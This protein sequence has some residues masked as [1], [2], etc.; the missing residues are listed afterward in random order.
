MAASLR[1]PPGA[2]DAT[3]HCEIHGHDGIEEDTRDKGADDST[4]LGEAGLEAVGGLGSEGDGDGEREDDSR[5]AQREG[6]TQAQRAL[7][8]LEQVA[9]GVVDGRDGGFAPPAVRRAPQWYSSL[10]FLRG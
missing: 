7:A 4:G 2:D 10:G 3:Q 9:S 6:E 5:V 8:L 1:L